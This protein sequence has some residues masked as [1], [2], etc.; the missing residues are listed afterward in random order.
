[1]CCCVFDCLLDAVVAYDRYFVQKKDALGVPGFSP[2]QK[3]TCVLCFLTYGTSADQLDE[4]IQMVETMVHETVSRF[5]SAIIACFSDTYL[6][7]PTVVDLKFFNQLRE[8]RLDLVLGLSRC[9][10]VAVEKLPND[11]ERCLPR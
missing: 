1:M 4:Y 11:M 7:S 10:E 3:L 9:H 2:H 8:S 6:H 5:C